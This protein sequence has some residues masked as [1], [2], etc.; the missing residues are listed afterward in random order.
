[1]RFDFDYYV[2]KHIP[3]VKAKC[4]DF[5]LKEVRL[6]RGS[7]MVDGAPPKF[8]LIGELVFPSV[9]NL[10]DVLARHGTEIMGD[11]PNYSNVQPRIQITEA[12]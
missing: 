6:M 12:I 3:M 2:E 11:I 7:A 1:L 5:G 4:A 8:E 10:Q 9:E